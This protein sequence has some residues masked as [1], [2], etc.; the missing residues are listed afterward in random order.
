MNSDISFDIDEINTKPGGG[1]AFLGDDQFDLNDNSDEKDPREFFF[2]EN[3]DEQLNIG[4][5]IMT[6][7]NSQ[8]E[9]DELNVNNIAV[10]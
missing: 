7:N 5:P 9:I 2:E 6:A 10:E 4:V 8:D 3:K 1:T